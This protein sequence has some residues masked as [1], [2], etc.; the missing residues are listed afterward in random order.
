M[1]HLL[2]NADPEIETPRPQAQG[3][4]WNRDLLFKVPADHPEVARLQ[5]RYKK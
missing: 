3:G 2:C 1:S 5:G 4:E